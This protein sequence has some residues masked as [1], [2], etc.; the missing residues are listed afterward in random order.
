M[1]TFPIEEVRAELEMEHSLREVRSQATEEL[2]PA[3]V[4]EAVTARPEIAVVPASPRIFR[5]KRCDGLDSQLAGTVGLDSMKFAGES[6]SH[7][8]RRGA[9]PCDLRQGRTGQPAPWN[10]GQGAAPAPR[11]QPLGPPS[12]GTP[13]RQRPR[14]W[15][16]AAIFAATLLT[17]S[18]VLFGQKTAREYLEESKPAALSDDVAD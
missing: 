2:G 9:S 4:P 8:P 11:G 12:P 5:K 13:S 16:R 15:H 7:A 17:F 3:G 14:P 1:R 6:G 10:P 18:N